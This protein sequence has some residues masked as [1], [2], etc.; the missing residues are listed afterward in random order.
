MSAPSPDRYLGAGRQ[1]TPDPSETQFDVQA[2]LQP[3]WRSSLLRL[4]CRAFTTVY[5]RREVDGLENL[6]TGPAV[7]CF[8]HQNWID[9]IFLLAALPGK[10]RCTFFGPA[11]NEMR[12]G[13][14][15]RLMRWS[16]MCIP[17]PRARRSLVAATRRA[18]RLL[19]MGH[20]VAIAGEGRIHSGEAVVL[21]LM[22]GPAYLSLRAG[23]PLVPIAING[24]SWLAFR[25]RVRIRIGRPIEVRRVAARSGMPDAVA[26]LTN[27]ARLD[28]VALASGYPDPPPGHLV[29]GWFTE[30]FNDWPEGARPAVPGR[31]KVPGTSPR[32]AR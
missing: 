1:R 31:E 16:G 29:G 3:A 14:R 6:P 10:P 22:E 30:L 17:F 15:N 9:P 8:S 24:T 5:A 19:G 4:A 11:Q 26:D 28:L 13:F 12:H 23:L 32:G 25:R 18:E 27:R 2:P 7:L 20:W 21:P